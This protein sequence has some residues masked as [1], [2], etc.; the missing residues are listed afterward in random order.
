MDLFYENFETNFILDLLKQEVVKKSLAYMITYKQYQ[1]L[2]VIPKPF[3]IEISNDEITILALLYV[4][5]DIKEYSNHINCSI[6]S[7]QK[8]FWEM[9][10]FKDIEIK[11]INPIA[12][13]HTIIS[14]EDDVNLKSID[15][16]LKGSF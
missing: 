2:N 13:F 4:G 11:Y 16:L 10:E 7:F 6:V 8:I 1:N 14:I 12:L 15:H 9:H 5:F 3:H